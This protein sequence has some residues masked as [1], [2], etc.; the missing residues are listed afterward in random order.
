[1]SF[2]LSNEYETLMDLINRVFKPYLDMLIIIFIDDILIYSRN[3]EDHASHIRIVLHTL[4]IRSYMLNALNVSFFLESLK[5]I[6]HIVFGEGTKVDTQKIE[7]VQNWPRHISPSDMRSFIDLA[8]YYRM[9][10]EV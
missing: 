8:G 3:K 4:K 5:F 1:M 10:V 9:F 2:I 7:V 6:G